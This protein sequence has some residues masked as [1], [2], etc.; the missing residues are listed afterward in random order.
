MGV[1]GHK[2]ITAIS[3]DFIFTQK[4]D[5]TI[6]KNG[7]FEFD[8]SNQSEIFQLIWISSWKIKVC[9]S[10]NIHFWSSSS[11][12]CCSCR[13]SSKKCWSASITSWKMMSGSHQW[14]ELGLVSVIAII[15]CRVIMISTHRRSSRSGS[16][17]TKSEK[18]CHFSARHLGFE[19]TSESSVFGFRCQFAI[20]RL[21]VFFF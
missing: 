4:I 15:Y 6:F 12:S 21:N 13:W 18:I 10:K 1:R 17:W 19:S 3:W 2:K 5:C 16:V 7:G 20:S 9:F 11:C 14:I 8:F